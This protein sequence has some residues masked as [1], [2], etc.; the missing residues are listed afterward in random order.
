MTRTFTASVREEDGEYIAQAHEVDVEGHGANLDDALA[1]LREE[2]ELYFKPGAAVVPE[3][4]R[5]EVDVPARRPAALCLVRLPLVLVQ[6]LFRWL[7]K[8]PILYGLLVLTWKNV[9][10][11]WVRTIDAKDYADRLASVHFE[12]GI[13]ALRHQHSQAAVLDNKLAVAGGVSLAI[14][15]LIP[16]ALATFEIEL[17][18]LLLERW[19]IIVGGIVLLLAFAHSAKGLWPRSYGALPELRRIRKLARANWT[20]EDARWSVAASV[21]QAVEV[22]ERVMLSR[23]AAVKLTYSLLIAG[24]VLVGGAFV[25]SLIRGSNPTVPAEPTA[26][27]GW[28]FR[29]HVPL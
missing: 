13:A 26:L 6:L 25:L 17:A 4:H 20:D 11:D 7:M 19:L 28:A 5:I 3:V 10:T 15:A 14:I 2:V 23:V 22:N 18:E 21:E 12:T 16:S 1:N 8:A 9:N 29:L 24:V 27:V